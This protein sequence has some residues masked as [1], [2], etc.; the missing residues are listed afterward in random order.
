MCPLMELATGFELPADVEL[1]A[2]VTVH[3][4]FSTAMPLATPCWGNVSQLFVDQPMDELLSAILLLRYIEWLLKKVEIKV[5]K[6]IS[7]R[8]K[9]LQRLQKQPKKAKLEWRRIL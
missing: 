7:I 1:M 8:W 5:F 2:S 6:K 4:D 3:L 9:N